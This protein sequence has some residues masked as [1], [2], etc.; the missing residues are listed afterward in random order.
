MPKEGKNPRDKKRINLHVTYMGAG[1]I[2]T[3]TAFTIT[4]LGSSVFTRLG[5]TVVGTPLLIWNQ[6]GVNK[7]TI[8]KSTV[9]E[10]SSETIV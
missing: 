7:G 10:N 5:S 8:A 3:T 2:S 1:T 6:V 9:A 4:V